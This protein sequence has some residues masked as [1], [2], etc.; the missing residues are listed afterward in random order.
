MKNYV[1]I[2]YG[3]LFEQKLNLHIPSSDDFD[4]FIYFHGGGLETGSRVADAYLGGLEEHNIAI[5]SVEYR[6][7]PNAKYPDFIEDCALAISYLFENIN[8]YGKCKKIFVGGS[9]AGAYI[10]MMLCFDR[11]YL[12]KYNIPLNAIAG[13]LHNAGQPTS[14]FNVLREKG[15]D[16]RRIIVDE[17]APVYFIGI[18]KEYPPMLFVVADNDIAGRYEQT[19]MMMAA[20]KDFGYD[21]SKIDFKLMENFDHNEYSHADNENGI[22]CFTQLVIDFVNKYK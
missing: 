14:H 4:L 8:K 9:S 3:E 18:E 5:A 20:M 15:I 17:T 1:D 10:S 2:S 19:M 7:Y 13:Y 21:M 11:K 6:M 22:N 16:S 12:G